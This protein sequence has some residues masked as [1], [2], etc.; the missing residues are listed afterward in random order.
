MIKHIFLLNK[1]NSNDVLHTIQQHKIIQKM[2]SFPSIYPNPIPGGQKQ[3]DFFPEKNILQ[4]D[5]NIFAIGKVLQALKL[6]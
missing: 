1:T 2:F 5:Y 4:T 3:G 6:N